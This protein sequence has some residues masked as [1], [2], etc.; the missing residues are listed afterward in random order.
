MSFWIVDFDVPAL[1]LISKNMQIWNR[2]SNKSFYFEKLRFHS[3]NTTYVS[4]HEK[5]RQYFCLRYLLFSFS[6]ELLKL[7]GVSFYGYSF[8]RFTIIVCHV[9]CQS[10][11][12]WFHIFKCFLIAS[13]SFATLLTLFS[14]FWTDCNECDTFYLHLLWFLYTCLNP[15]YWMRQGFKLPLFCWFVNFSLIIFEIV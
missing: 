4:N 6:R 8:F 14:S 7:L 12:G 10:F 9:S 11:V 2:T 13:G 15:H 3:S 1:S 5:L